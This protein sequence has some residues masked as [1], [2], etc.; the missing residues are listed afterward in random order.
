MQFY[1]RSKLLYFFL[2]VYNELN[3]FP[4]AG[5]SNLS[6]R[7]F[8]DYLLAD[9]PIILGLELKSFNLKVYSLEIKFNRFANKKCSALRETNYHVTL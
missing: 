1:F 9:F 2:N 6:R 4:L 8:H 3:R 7:T 5:R